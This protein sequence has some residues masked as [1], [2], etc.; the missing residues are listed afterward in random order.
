MNPFLFKGTSLRQSKNH[1]FRPMNQRAINWILLFSLALIWGSSF[2]LMKQAMGTEENPIFSDTQVGALRIVIAGLALLPMALRNLPRLKNIKN[3]LPLLIVGLCGNFFPA[4]LFTYA[5]TGI[6]TGYTG[7][8]N[9]CTPIF[10]IIIGVVVFGDR[11]SN[12]QILGVSIGTVGVI[13]L[14][15]AGNNLSSSGSWMHIGSVILATLC[16]AISV[17][18]IKNKL[19][20]LKST[21]IASLAFFLLLI[22]SIV[23][24]FLVGAHKTI[25]VHPDGTS[26]LTY[27]I[28]LSV[29]GTAFAL[30]LFNQLI[31]NSSIVF[32]SSVTYLIPII[33]A[34]IG[35]AIGEE[36]IALQFIMMFVVIIGVFIANFN[37]K[38]KKS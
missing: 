17:N 4:F 18:T 3:I 16:Y 20:H 32:A 37:P 29:V 21:E 34:L 38:T 9:S 13:G 19:Q 36:I 33:A 15:L 26:G 2:I 35:L 7:M 6:S 5:E 14:S 8:L 25:A 23:I 11:L 10:A 12:R 30:I 22:P 1:Y 31:A 27:I 24:S 28:I